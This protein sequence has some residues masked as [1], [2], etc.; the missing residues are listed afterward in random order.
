MKKILNK[1]LPIK[2]IGYSFMVIVIHSYNAEFL[3]T[4]RIENFFAHEFLWR[5]LRY[6]SLY[7]NI[8][9]LEAQIV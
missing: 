5:Q 4:S 2:T 7:Q 3:E 8:Y 9:F 1:L 6:F